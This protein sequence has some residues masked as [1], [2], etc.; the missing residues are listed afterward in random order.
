MERMNKMKYRVV[1]ELETFDF[2]EGFIVDIEDGLGSLVFMIDNVTIKS[3]NPCNRDIMDMRTNQLKLTF[4]NAVIKSMVEEGYKL[5][6]ADNQLQEVVEDRVIDNDGYGEVFRSF[7][8]SCY[9]DSIQEL[10]P[11]EYH[12]NINTDYQTY[13]VIV[14]CEETLTEWDKFMRKEN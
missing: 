11:N 3:G 1:N 4:K 9:F 12:L 10:E 5:Y 8:G 6:D 2:N 7:I 13:S 14:K